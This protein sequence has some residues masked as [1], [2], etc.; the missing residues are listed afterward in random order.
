MNFSGLN[1]TEIVSLLKPCLRKPFVFLE[2]ANFD[3]ENNDSFLFRDF[4]KVLTFSHGQDASKFLRKA[5]GF[6][7]KKQWLCGF[8]SYE[9]GYYLE[10]ALYHL[11]NKNNFPLAWLAVSKKPITISGAKHCRQDN[12]TQESFMVKNIKPNISY[13]QYA[14]TI[15]KIKTYLET[16]ANYQ[17]N[18]TFKIKFCFYGDVLS[19]YLALRN[20]Q[21]TSYMALINTGKHFIVSLSPELFYRT[22]GDRITTRP[23]KG[24]FMRGKNAF[25]DGINEKKL[26]TDK[27]IISE[28]LMIV[29]LLRN[30]LGRVSEKVRVPR[31]FCAEKYKTLFQMT[32]TVSARLKPNSAIPQIFSALFPSGSVTGA[33]KIKTMEII[34][35]LEEEP[36]NIYTGAIGYMSAAKSCFNVAIRTAAISCG[37]GELGV[38]GGIVYD[39]SAKK[40]YEE[41]LLKA[42]FLTDSLKDFSLIESVLWEPCLGYYLLNPHL[43]RLKRSCK[44]FSININSGQL[45]KE[46][47]VLAKTLKTKANS[48]KIRI[49]VDSDGKFF[50]EKSSLKGENL[51]ITVK[52]SKQT[53]DPENILLYHKTT[54]RK[55]YEEERAKA[56]REGFFEVIFLN[57]YAELTEGSITNLFVL[58]NNILYTPP[59]KCGL[60]PGVLR[61]H[62]LINGAAKEKVLYEKD[63][64]TAQKIYIG[65]SVRGLLLAKLAC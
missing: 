5:Q 7:D 15:G 8:F 32:S 35:E 51:P 55:L 46:L 23:M 54:S 28:N 36:R 65:N 9:F 10:P 53:T 3:K 4:S 52:I 22:E 38:G 50:I 14:K 20:A 57:K 26:T 6:L 58:K 29:D 62:L 45:K 64:K 56:G 31:L 39:S 19:F 59:V 27:K 16:G 25:R 11:K 42:K 44:Y 60:L 40:E 18:F 37:K 21:P 61:Q 1:E 49:M 47:A 63:L 48:F 41:A 24:T 43:E 2:T 13:S 17:T 34:K 12:F 30:D 33:P